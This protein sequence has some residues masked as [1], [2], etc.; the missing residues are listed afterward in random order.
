MKMPENYGR[1]LTFNDRGVPSSDQ[2]NGS[3]ES[4]LP[5]KATQDKKRI[6]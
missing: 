1:L 3:P 2:F 6:P 5:S 4:R